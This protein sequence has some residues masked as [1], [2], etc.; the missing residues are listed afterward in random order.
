MEGMTQ[1]TPSQWRILTNLL[2]KGVFPLNQQVERSVFLLSLP[3][4][5]LGEPV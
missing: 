5:W 3:P 1:I 4:K 2:G